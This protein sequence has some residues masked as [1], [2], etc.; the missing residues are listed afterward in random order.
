MA[1]SSKTQQ[2]QSTQAQIAAGLVD[3][4][5]ALKRQ[6]AELTALLSELRSDMKALRAERGAKEEPKVVVVPVPADKGDGGVT[7]ES[8]PS[9]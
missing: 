4:N 3:E 8:D 7:P 6:I 2:A 1:K 9:W 5:R